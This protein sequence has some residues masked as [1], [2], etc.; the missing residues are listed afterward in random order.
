L[1]AEHEDPDP[2]VAR[3]DLAGHTGADPGDVIGVERM[4]L[5]VYLQLA[6]A[7]Q[8]HVDLLLAVFAVIVLGVALEI[9]RHVDDLHAEGFDP[10]LGA[11]TL[12]RPS[13]DG[14]Q[15]VDLLHRVVAHRGP[16]LGPASVD[17]AILFDSHERSCFSV[18][19]R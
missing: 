11:R 16:S 13:I 14:L 4:A 18:A 9:G 7:A 6:A 5:A 12:E 8:R 2:V 3:P 1:A 17:A 15:L 10:Q 19:W